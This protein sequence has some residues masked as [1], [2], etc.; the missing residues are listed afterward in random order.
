MLDA[1]RSTFLAP[2][3]ATTSLTTLTPRL[4]FGDFDSLVYIVPASLLSL[5]LIDRGLYPSCGPGCT[6]NVWISPLIANETTH[7]LD[8]T[9]MFRTQVWPN[10]SR[11]GARVSQTFP[12]GGARAFQD[13]SSPWSSCLQDNPSP[14]SPCLQNTSRSG[15]RVSQILLQRGARVSK[16]FEEE[17]VSPTISSLESPCLKF[18]SLEP[19]SPSSCQTRSPCLPVHFRKGARVSKTISK[20]SPCLQNASQAEPV[21]PTLPFR[22]FT[23]HPP[24]TPPFRP[25][26][27]PNGFPNPNNL[28]ATPLKPTSSL[29]PPS[30]RKRLIP[31][32]PPPSNT[33][34][35]KPLPNTFQ[36]LWTLLILIDTHNRP[37]RYPGRLTPPTNQHLIFPARARRRSRDARRCR[38]R[39]PCACGTVAR[40]IGVRPCFGE[41]VVRGCGVEGDVGGWEEVEEC[42]V[43]G[44]S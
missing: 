18:F 5:Q 24:S 15:A 26:T 20:W 4:P 19:V 38:C 25:P 11:A 22:P 35:Q 13:N 30:P 41:V 39:R 31:S 36:H 33:S 16:S 12:D 10:T 2:C 21:S 27:I 44:G 40:W 29:R 8:A 7:S 14:W 23:L 3:R 32:S 34:P 28:L 43:C 1:R 17:P 42:C 6:F 37:R 9:W